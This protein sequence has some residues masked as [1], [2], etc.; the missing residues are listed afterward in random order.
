MRKEIDDWD[1]GLGFTMG[2]MTTMLVIW[3]WTIIFVDFSSTQIDAVNRGKAEW[4]V[5]TNYHQ[6]KIEFRWKE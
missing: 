1:V 4:V 2:V 5:K 6:P 3:I